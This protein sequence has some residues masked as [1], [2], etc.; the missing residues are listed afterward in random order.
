MVYMS[1]TYD[2]DNYRKG[3]RFS[4]DLD[5]ADRKGYTRSDAFM[6]GYMDQADR[7]PMWHRATCS[8]QHGHMDCA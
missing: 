4:G 5:S 2:K 1:E 8:E 7:L 3:W 6:D